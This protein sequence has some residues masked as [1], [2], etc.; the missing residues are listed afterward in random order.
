MLNRATGVRNERKPYSPR[1]PRDE[2]REQVL[3]AALRV[4]DRR[5]FGGLSVEATAEAADLSKTVVYDAVGNRDEL[6]RA[7]IARE[8]ARAVRDVAAAL[9]VPPLE[10][11]EDLLTQ[12][13]ASLLEAVREHPATW[14][15]ILLPPEG[16]PPK[17]R[18]AVDAHRAELRSQ[19]EPVVSW[20]LGELE[21]DDI[22]PEI[23]TYAL[24][25]TVENGIRMTLTDP[26]RFEVERLVD[27]A[28]AIIRRVA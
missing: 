10:S 12:G 24:L 17:L 21:A 18:D 15:L 11:P 27:F 6:L 2:R 20:A 25:A 1:R 26:D 16:T 23:A 5:G 9:P 19:L 22:D 4:L 28:R 7:L 13:I 3:D 8:Q 14:R